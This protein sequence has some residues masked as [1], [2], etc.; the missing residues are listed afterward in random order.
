MLDLKF[1]RENTDKVKK[2]IKDRGIT[3]DIEGLLSL[4]EKRRGILKE[5]EDIRYKKNVASDEIA[6]LLKEK[7]DA[8][9]KIAEMKAISEKE[10]KL[11]DDLKSIEKELQGALFNI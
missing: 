5:V 1:I 8:K 11:E 7:K 10:K 6:K 3:V 2:A 4:D 9:A